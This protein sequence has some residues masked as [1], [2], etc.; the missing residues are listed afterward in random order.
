MIRRSKR[1]SPQP[2]L[3]SI[4]FAVV[5]LIAIFC[6]IAPPV[7]ATKF[8]AERHPTEHD[9]VIGI[10]KF[11]FL[12]SVGQ[13]VT[14]AVSRPGNNVRIC[15]S[16]TTLDSCLSFLSEHTGILVSGKFDIVISWSHFC[17]RGL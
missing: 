11:W 10:G 6:L 12:V 1:K 2:I 4:S 14:E 16:P 3:F 9:V 17:K 7:K 5:A 8:T 15:F 13:I